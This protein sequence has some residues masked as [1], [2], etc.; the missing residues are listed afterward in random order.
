MLVE[1]LVFDWA[2]SS[3][4]RFEAQDQWERLLTAGLARD[5]EQLRLEFLEKRKDG[6]PKA[7]VDK[8]VLA[9]EARIA[10]FRRVV[11]RGRTAPVTTA[12]ILAPIATPARVLL[13]LLSPGWSTLHRNSGRSGKRVSHRV[14]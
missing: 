13:G 5:F 7:V 8:W 10:Q 4:N 9:Q 3:A 12:P 6:D 2:Q 1:A 14:A 11:D